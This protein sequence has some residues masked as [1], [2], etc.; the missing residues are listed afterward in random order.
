MDTYESLF[1]AL[2]ISLKEAKVY[3]S[4][5]KEGPSSVRQ[6]AAA[7]GM[8]RGTVYDVLKVLQVNGLVR[9]Y[10]AETRQYFV[11]TS[12]HRLEE[13]AAEKEAAL[14]SA[15]ADLSV[16]VS[17]LETL[18]DGGDRQPIVRMYEGTEGVRAILEDVLVSVEKLNDK[19]YFVYSSSAV[20]SAGLYAGFPDFT[21]KRLTKEIYVKNIS[22]GT[23]GVTSG[24][25]ERKHV[26]S[27]AG[28]PTYVLIYAGKVANIF[29][30]Q[31]G[32]FT[33]LIVDNRAMYETQRV[34][35]FELWD[36]LPS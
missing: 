10:N 3:L 35:F 11:A 36:R 33:G 12:P 30:D 4:L 17:Q 6:L 16:M 19:E 15:T 34:L 8:N 31:R 1:E 28:A 2:G 25:D 14:R 9:F 20:R 26:M 13:I 29:L 7:T 32:E 22:F 24:L 21:A 18:Y 27:V 5:M 23:P